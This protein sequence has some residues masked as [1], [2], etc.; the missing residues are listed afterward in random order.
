[1]F[2]KNDNDDFIRMIVTRMVNYI[3]DEHPQT[4]K[5]MALM[6]D[7]LYE[8]IIEE[9]DDM[10]ADDVWTKD[11]I[12]ETMTACLHVVTISHPSIPLHLQSGLD[13]PHHHPHQHQHQHHEHVVKITK[14]LE[15][16][17][18]IPQPVQRTPEWHKAR[19]NLIT[20]SNAHKALGT[21]CAQNSL[22]YEKC[23]PFENSFGGQQQPLQLTKDKDND[24]D[25]EEQ[26]SRM[27]VNTINT[28]SPMHWG[29]KYEPLSVQIYEIIYNTKIADF[30]CIP[31][32][33]PE[34]SFLGASPDGINSDPHSPLYGR[35]LE[36]KN[37]VNRPITG[38]PKK[39]YAV[40]M[41]MQMEVCDLPDCDF[42]E[43]KFTE[44]LSVDDFTDF[45]LSN[46][47]T[48]RA[49][50]ASRATHTHAPTPSFPP[51][52]TSVQGAPIPKFCGMVLQFQ[53]AMNPNPTYKYHIWDWVEDTLDMIDEIEHQII[54]KMRREHG[55]GKIR[56]METRFWKL[57]V[58]SCAYIQRDP[59]WFDTNAPQFKSVWDT[60]LTERVSGHEHRAPKS[61]PRATP[62]RESPFSTTTP[63]IDYSTCIFKI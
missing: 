56:L 11:E 45:V 62:T 39:E 53:H 35:M 9:F 20:A 42:L 5:D 15:Y 54:T 24:S 32:Q 40:Q 16:L 25:N 47:S 59:L 4:I 19:Y 48:H 57:D 60:I 22:I 33:N 18:S 30:G 3:N 55:A 1:M 46:V 10:F 29:Q 61:R 43:T 26:E 37:I 6:F 51:M 21:Q 49:S 13:A 44:F 12:L 50:R 14:H 2:G 28:N 17:K 52:M 38:I 31:H 7:D 23:Q 41:Q 63:S 36:I 8:Y 27:F 58:Y 34:F